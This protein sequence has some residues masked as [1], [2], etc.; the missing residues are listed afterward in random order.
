VASPGVNVVGFFRAEFGH[1]EAARRLVAGLDTAGIPYASVTVQTPHH[2]ERAEFAERKL[3]APWPTNVVCLNPEHLLEF[4]RGKEASLLDERYTIGVWCWEASVFP[5]SLRPALDLVDEIWVASEYVAEIISA[6]TDKPVLTFPLPVE[7]GPPPTLTREQLGLSPDRFTFLFAFDFFSTAERKNPVG[8]VEAF[9][10]AVEPG[11]GPELVIKSINGNRY[12]ADFTRLRK[13]ASRHADIKLVDKYA[14]QEEMRSLVAGADAFVSLHRSE[15]FGLSLAEAMAYAKPVV[16]TRYSGNLTFMD[17]ENSYLV[18]Y[19][20][21]QIPPG[22]PNYP[23]GALW[24]DPD[25]DDAAAS[26]RRVLENTTEATERGRLGQETIASRHSL[27]RTGEFLRGR[28]S[29]VAGRKTTRTVPQ[30]ATGRAR[31]F[32]ASGPTLDWNLPSPRYGRLGP[33][34]RHALLRVLRP[35]LVRQREWEA[36]VVDALTHFEEVEQERV[37]ALERELAETQDRLERLVGQL[38]AQPYA[39]PEAGRSGS[40]Y[41]SFEDV[42][43][44]TEDRVKEL[45]RPYVSLVAPHAPVLDVGCGRGEFLDLLRDAGAEAVGVDIDEGMV[46]RARA[47]GH[48]VELGDALDYLERQPAGRFGAIFAAQ[49]IEH[50]PYDAFLRF[51]RLARGQLPP[52]GLLIAETINPHSIQAFKTFWT[53][54]THE[55][56]IF[57]EVAV[58]LALIEGYE[59]AEAIYARGIGDDEADRREQTEFALVARR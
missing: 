20:L 46:E 13:A 4:A 25:L 47:K 27:T 11:S 39:D 54:P 6:E 12:Q 59:S 24:A 19:G 51:L 29:E 10:R 53:D 23:A 31:R 43:R 16:A 49:V 55:A 2:R 32:L 17:E 18:D 21:T 3:E 34:A 15:G 8:L 40:T 57:P 42:F 5:A 48:E 56:P 33:F 50:L 58:A 41:A 26:M 9:S 22:L 37:R 30:T 52:G 45:L 7:I 35:Y 36:L 14:S 44:G 38:Y 28:L 1:G